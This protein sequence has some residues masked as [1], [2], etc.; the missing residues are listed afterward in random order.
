NT[1]ANGNSHFDRN[2]S[3]AFINFHFLSL[4]CYTFMIAHTKIPHN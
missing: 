1:F 3:N 2:R 4:S